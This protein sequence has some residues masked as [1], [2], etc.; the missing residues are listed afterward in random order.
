M[1]FNISGT[2][3]K[4]NIYIFKRDLKA[5]DILTTNDISCG[6]FQLA[7]F[8]FLCERK[9]NSIYIKVNYQNQ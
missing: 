4:W 7:L 9:K 8:F 2:R 6:S 1:D 5:K 3:E